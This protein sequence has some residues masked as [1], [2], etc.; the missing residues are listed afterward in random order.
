LIFVVER[1]SEWFEYFVLKK[2]I[3]DENFGV[4]GS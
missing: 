3:I 1:V 4:F 2:K